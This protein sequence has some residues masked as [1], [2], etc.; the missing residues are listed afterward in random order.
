MITYQTA[1]S[2]TKTDYETKINGEPFNLIAAGIVR[3]EAFDQGESISTDNTNITFDTTKISIAWGQLPLSV[4]TYAPVI[5]GYKSGDTEGTLLIG[6]VESPLK[7]I[8]E[9]DGREENNPADVLILAKNCYITLSNFKAW[10]TLR[11]N[12]FNS[13]SDSAIVAAIVVSGLDYITPTFTFKG[14]KI[15]EEQPLPLPTDQVTIANI[16]SGAAQ[17][18]WQQLSGRLF[19]SMDEQNVKG[20]VIEEESKI[21]VLEE[22]TKY[23]PGTALASKFSTTLIRSLL[24]PYIIGT[25]NIYRA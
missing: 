2:T 18:A 21:D 4:G 9:R 12:A 6:G 20:N 1:G 16:E 23:Q 7:L 24:K 25:N 11:G 5:Y 19:V 13:F 22:L 14:T 17:A 3:I 15:N 8:I 10:A